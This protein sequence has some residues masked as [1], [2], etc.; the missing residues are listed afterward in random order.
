VPSYAYVFVRTDIPIASQ[1]VQVGHACLEAGN[2]FAQPQG[3]CHLVL[4][5]VASEARLLEA[6][7]W[8]NAAGIRSIT[9]FEPDDAPGYTAICTEP[10]AGPT[11]RL[12]KRFNLWR[13]PCA[14]GSGASEQEPGLGRAPPMCS[15]S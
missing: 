6:A 11:R 7:A 15:A 12:L 3:P 4:F 2:R 10:V 14:R 1:L 8:L 13:L 9:F 5:G